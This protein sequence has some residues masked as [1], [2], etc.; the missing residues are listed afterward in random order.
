MVSTPFSN[1]AYNISITLPQ[2]ATNFDPQSTVCI[3]SGLIKIIDCFKSQRLEP[4]LTNTTDVYSVIAFTIVWSV[5]KSSKNRHM[6]HVH[7]CPWTVSAVENW[8]QINAGNLIRQRGNQKLRT[9]ISTFL[10]VCISHHQDVP[11]G[12]TRVEI[13]DHEVPHTRDGVPVLSSHIPKLG[14]DSA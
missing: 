8:K 6:I 10:H 12:V 5:S 13:D 2:T 1:F 3:P 14:A 9:I 4:A 11:H 7:V